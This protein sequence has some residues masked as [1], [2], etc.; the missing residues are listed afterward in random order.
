MAI[1]K[2]SFNQ[3]PEKEEKPK[4]EKPVK[5]KQPKTKAKRKVNLKVIV[6]IA[7]FSISPR[8]GKRTIVEIILN[9]V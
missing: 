8:N 4:K 6:L 2:S 9:N 3:K 5:E 1:Y 7:S